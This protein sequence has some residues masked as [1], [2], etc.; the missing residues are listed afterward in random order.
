MRRQSQ[1]FRLEAP[2]G[3]WNTRDSID[4]VPPT[5]ALT[6]T[7]WI[8]DLGE[9]RTRPGY[10]EHCW[11]GDI[12]T[13]S[14]LLSNP[15]FETAGAGGVD[16]FANWVEGVDIQGSSPPDIDEYV[17]NETVIIHGGS[18]SA[19]CV[20]GTEPPPTFVSN[21]FVYQDVTV[22]PGETYNLTYWVYSNLVY[23][24]YFISASHYSLYDVT[25]SDWIIEKTIITTPF[26]TWTE[27]SLSFV[28]PAGCVS[29]R[30]KLGAEYG[31][32]AGEAYFDDVSIK[33]TETLGDVETLAVYEK[34]TVNKLIACAENGFYDVSTSGSPAAITND[35]TAFT[36]NR[37]QS[38]NFD[39]KIGF[40]N[41]TDK[42]KYYPN[43]SGNLDDFTGGN[44]ITGPTE[45]SLIGIHSFK[46][47]TW[48]WEKNS[49]DVWYSALNT[50]GGALTQFPLSRVGQFGGNLVAMTTWTHDGGSGPDDYAV[51]IMSS[52]ECI[53]YQ[54]S[55]PSIGGD[56]A[57]VGIYN[58]GE[59]LSIRSVAKYGG[60][61][62]IITRLDYVNLARVIPGIEADVTKSKVVGALR[63]A[64]GTGGSLWG[65]E[66]LTYP[67]RQLAI[68]NVPV[69]A[70]EEYQ[71]HVMN[72]VTG[73]W[74]K[75]ENIVSH[76]WQVFNNNLYF[77]S[78]NGYIYEFDVGNSDAGEEIYS[79]MQTAWLPIGGYINKMFT[80]IREFIRV[81]ATIETVNQFATDYQ[82]FDD[83]QYPVS[84]SSGTADWGDPWGTPWTAREQVYKEYQSVG[85]YGEVISLRKRL[86]TKQRVKYLGATWLYRQGERL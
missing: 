60:D 83:Q 6:L 11:L 81:N 61:V 52:G 80:A 74:C 46:G 12:L 17:R 77:G 1:T 31:G 53:I 41:G 16:V 55:A 22:T 26:E 78:S 73:A 69:V 50:L 68:F 19:E 71:Q 48:W 84:V 57:L 28:A 3:G 39:G 85:T 49:Q 58:I 75:W 66:A 18:D 14:E 42:P 63:D 76:T 86:S 4:N 8:P 30:L 54:G 29:V 7:N 38:A 9:M 34:G 51:F 37:W 5:D 70:N 13:G 59:P 20:G 79:E 23:G 10:V 32:V 62:L 25:N 82:D 64:I 21:G 44:A 33:L 72:T 27:R 24:T 67:K 45:T 2:I 40:A 65:W 56:W 35:G 47:R 36:V 43:G 15:G